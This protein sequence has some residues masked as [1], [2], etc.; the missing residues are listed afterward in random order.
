MDLFDVVQL[1]ITMMV[2][3][4]AILL[5]LMLMSIPADEMMLVMTITIFQMIFQ[6]TFF[7]VLK[8]EKQQVCVFS[9]QL[10]FEPSRL[11]A[12]DYTVQDSV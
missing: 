3:Y 7:L 12:H 8:D 11:I 5:V 9:V 4:A 1:V 10:K 2:G 6:M